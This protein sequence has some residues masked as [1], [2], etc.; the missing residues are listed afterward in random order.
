MAHRSDYLTHIHK[1]QKGYVERACID[2][3]ETQFDAIA[4]TGISGALMGPVIAYKL[5]KSMIPIRKT[6]DAAHTLDR[7]EAPEEPCKYVIIDD[8]I[9]SGATINRIMDGIETEYPDSHHE[10]IGIYTYNKMYPYAEPD[11]K[12]WSK[13]DSQF[14]SYQ[15][16]PT[17]SEI[18]Q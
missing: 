13:E 6:T 7:V 11:F 1:N 14:K 3:A 4:F 16:I 9:S 15:I 5:G 17:K 10:C 18:S 12:R 8:Q 2:L